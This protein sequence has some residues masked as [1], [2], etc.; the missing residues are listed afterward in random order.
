VPLLQHVEHISASGLDA[1]AYDA[2]V[3]AAKPKRARKSSPSRALVAPA[4]AATK[5]AAAA[6]SE[7]AAASEGAA[8]AA[9]A[10]AVAAAAAAVA[11][12]AE[13]AAEAEVVDESDFFGG[14]SDEASEPP[15]T[16]GGRSVGLDASGLLVCVASPVASAA[17]SSAAWG[18]PS[19]I[20]AGS[21]LKQQPRTV[22]AFGL[23]LPEVRT[24]LWSHQRDAS[25]RVLTGLA[26]GKRGFADASAVGA[27]KTLT[28]LVAT[29]IGPWL[30]RQ[31][32]APSS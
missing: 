6:S 21:T 13:T 32:R 25:G 8:A 12:A 26:E 23:T 29:V 3:A 14:S 27:G 20:Q 31:T 7:A 15:S 5:A 9:A 28:A 17:S 24:K 22:D 16:R 19:N 18:E 4:E 10:A 30:R 1:F 2:P 11:A